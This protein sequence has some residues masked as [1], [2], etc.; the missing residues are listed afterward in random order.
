MDLEQVWFNLWHLGLAFLI[1]LPVAFD[2]ETEGRSAG[3]RTFPLVRKV[4]AAINKRVRP[5]AWFVGVIGAID[6]ELCESRGNK[7]PFGR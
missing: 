1:A 6:E 5:T 3:I 4:K 2:R 7:W